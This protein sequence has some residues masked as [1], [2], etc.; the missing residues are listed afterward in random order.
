MRLLPTKTA[1]RGKPKT[2]IT[3]T[4]RDSRRK[5]RFRTRIMMPWRPVGAD[6]GSMEIRP[7]TTENSWE[8]RWR[9]KNGEIVIAIVYF[10]DTLKNDRTP[11]RVVN[12][13]EYPL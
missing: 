6:I 11:R 7:G 9:K 10:R 8:S 2:R 12:E 1:S 5:A 3:P 4:T 13:N